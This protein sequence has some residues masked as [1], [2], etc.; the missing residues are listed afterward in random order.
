MATTKPPIVYDFSEL[1]KTLDKL[2]KLAP[3]TTPRTTIK[4][5]DTKKEGY[6]KKEGYEKKD[7]FTEVA[8]FFK[9][10]TRKAMGIALLVLII[11]MSCMSVLVV[12]LR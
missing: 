1:Q 7:F 8:Y 2:A 6:D 10:D 12:A 4:P 9:D 5:S 11:L 3:S